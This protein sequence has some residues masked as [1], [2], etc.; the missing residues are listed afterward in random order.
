MRQR[1]EKQERR[2]HGK[3]VSQQPHGQ[4]LPPTPPILPNP[5]GAM[6]PKYDEFT[7]QTHTNKLLSDMPEKEGENAISFVNRF[8]NACWDQ[9]VFL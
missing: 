5:T 7:K 8:D 4:I 6:D 9:L 3:Q 2:S 1:Q